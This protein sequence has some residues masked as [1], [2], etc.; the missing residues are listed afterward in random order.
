MR[1]TF[2]SLFILFSFAA[3]SQ[4]NKTNSPYTRYGYGVLA[5]QTFASQRGMG[6]IGYGLRNSKIINPLNPASFS[7]VDTMTFMLDFGVKGQAALMNDGSF[8]TSRRYNGGLEYLAIQIPLAK[9]LGM[10]IGIEP[11]SFVGYQYGDTSHVLNTVSSDVYSGSGGLNKVY[12][13]LSYHFLKRLSLGVNVGYLFGDITHERTNTYSTSTSFISSWPDSLR[14]SGLTYE[15][16]L[17]YVQKLSKNSEV[18]LGVVYAPKITTHTEVMFDSINYDAQGQITGY[19]VYYSTQ[20][21]V[22]Q[23]PETFGVGITYRKLNKLTVGADFRYEKWAEAKFYDQTNY[24]TNRMKINAGM[25]YIPN[26]MKNQLLSKIHYRAGAYF[27]NSYIIDSNGSKYN[28]Y[29][30]SVGFGIPMVD[31]RSFVNMA[32][33]YSRL[34]PQKTASMS[35]QYFKLT[36]SYT[37]NELWFFKRKLQ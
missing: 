37:F 22:C 25:E 14:M 10:G 5:D 11:V 29:G 13:T 35:E 24:L 30:V 15:F 27:A 31:R 33:E 4:S 28:E 36:L 34:A 9:G 12:G 8:G 3:F 2:I 32:F 20:D 6:G 1:I 17:Q 18:V 26:L 16:G 7:A 21:S 19:P 23:M